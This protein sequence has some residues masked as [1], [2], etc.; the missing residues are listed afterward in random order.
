MRKLFW[1]TLVLIFIVIVFAKKIV[2]FSADWLWFA[3]TGYILVLLNILKAKISLGI[4]FSFFFFIL[5]GLNLFL[6]FKFRPKTTYNFANKILDF[7]LPAKAESFFKKI[8]LFGLLFLSVIV[9]LEA[10]SRWELFS[11]FLNSS[12]FGTA[13]PI[14]HKDIGFYVFKLPF[15]KYF[16]SWLNFV[17]YL[18]LL[19]SA[20]IYFISKA[21]QYVF[22]ELYFTPKAKAHLFILIALILALKGFGYYLS[23]YSLLFSSRGIV[24]GATFTDVHVQL[25]VYKILVLLSAVMSLLA[26]VNIFIKNW[27]YL[28]GGILVLVLISFLGSG[29]YA[30]LIQKFVVTPNE[31]EKE[32]PYIKF[33]IQYTR[34]AYNLNKIEERDFLVREDLKASDIKENDATIKNIRLW[35]HRPLLKTYEQ[36]QEIRTYY[37]FFDV[38]NDR[39]IIDGSYVQTML[40]PRELAYSQLPSRI[41]INEHLTYTHGYGVCLGP[42]N[43][44]TQEGL[45]EFFIKDIPPVSL[46]GIKIKRPEIYYGEVSN[47]YCLVNTKSMEFD[48]PAGEKNVYSSYAG[49]GG[50]RLNSLLKKLLFAV[51]FSEFKIFFSSDI[52]SESRIMYYR[53][54]DEM[55]KKV[56]PLVYYEKDPY[57]VISNDGKLYW[58][59]DGYTASSHYPYSQPA[60]GGIG[61]YV[62]NSVKAVVDAYN[63]TMAFYIAD[64]E[65]P[66]IKAQSGIFPGVFHPLSQMPEDIR[67]H[68]R[69][70]ASYFSIQADMYALYHMTD[71][72][73]YYNKEDLW[74]I[75]AKTINGDER[76]M[77]PYY[78]ILRFPNAKKEEFILMIPFTPARK[79]NMIAWLAA[80]CDNPHYGSLLVYKFPKE[81]LIY[82]PSQIEA[83]IDQDTEISKQL[84]L[85][86]QTGSSVIRGSLLVIPIKDSLIYVQPLYLA[87]EKGQLPELKRVIVS[88][89]DRIAMEQTLEESLSKIFL[90][91]QVSITPEKEVQ[92]SAPED[93]LQELITK[94]V[95]YFNNAKSALKDGRWTEFGQNLEK[96]EEVLNKLNKLKE[97]KN[98]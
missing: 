62:R 92:F 98:V 54:I 84:T 77:E 67:E 65:D 9:G 94:A 1:V 83:R 33:N 59:C 30:G 7:H 36:L 79:N 68:I 40:S 73:V 97:E 57:M 31:I 16:Y 64:P 37:E 70:P 88:Y 47:Q 74:K 29:I 91:G 71:E 2:D 18:S 14:F 35:D 34:Q 86:N 96:L 28:A 24:F 41:W 12:S 38:D 26:L 56:T 19:I 3:K 45:P 21:I 10:A 43:K 69:Y 46:K 85:W 20:G 75:P 63:G 81:K 72:Q 61:N 93:K 8:A 25:P 82:G 13:D 49:G 32:K 23:C 52:T 5:V 78:S 4:L 39:Y 42:V 58:I 22:K 44:V 50:V 51:K 80:R 87:A 66:I 48:Y 27:R 11:Y 17:L 76:D 6:S 95:N 60:G 15:L 55:I 90:T 53:R 89:K